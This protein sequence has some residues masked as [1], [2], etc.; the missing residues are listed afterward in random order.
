MSDL[1]R[2][3]RRLARARFLIRAEFLIAVAAPLV[4][5]FLFLVAPGDMGGPMWEPSL[6]VQL[7]PWAGAAGVFLGLVWMIRLSR[8]RPEGGERTWRYRD[9]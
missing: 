8:P 5:A 4:V 1:E 7:L 9:F 3:R 2:R 6:L